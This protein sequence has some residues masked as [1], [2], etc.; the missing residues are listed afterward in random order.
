[1]LL[2]EAKI[3]IER[4]PMT[5]L[6]TGTYAAYRVSGESTRDIERFI[7]ESGIDLGPERV[8]SDEYHCTL[9]YSRLVHA[10]YVPSQTLSHR[11]RFKE[12]KVFES[13]ETKKRC[14]VMALE[15]P[16]LIARHRELMRVLGATYDFDDYI[17]HVTL[18]Y[19]MAPEW[20]GDLSKI[21]AFQ[22]DIFLEGEYS[23]EIG[24]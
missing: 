5:L 23:Q 24:G 19:C 16:T 14:L 21:P 4:Q 2:L 8:P 17:P 15:C 20:D 6:K 22:G 7:S 11:A 10:G 9:L 18:S 12:W 3:F 13:K 1:M